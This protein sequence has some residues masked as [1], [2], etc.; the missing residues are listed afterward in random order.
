MSAR[1]FH[2]RYH[3][4]ALAGFMPLSLE[5]RGAYQTLL[6]MIYDRGGPVIDNDRLLAGYM[7]CSPRKWR[8]IRDA[9][10]EKG[11]IRVTED[12]HLTNDRAEKELENDAKTSRKLAES[13]SNGGRVRAERAKK[14]N[15]NREGGQASLE[16]PSSLTRSHIP[17]LEDKASSSVP[18][19]ARERGPDPDLAKVMEAGRFTSIPNDIAQ[20]R[21]WREA[22]AD[23]EGDIL[24]VV[25]RE[26]ESLIGRTGRGPFK[27]KVFD[28]AVRQKLADDAREAEANRRTV[29]NIR[30]LEQRQR[31]EDAREAEEA[32]RFQRRATA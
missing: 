19:P 4:D 17:E 13:G 7:Q 10:I 3:S 30:Q 28:N 22:G 16:R 14:A 9:L 12:G 1:P 8:V 27:L 21:A 23:L 31:E 32:A 25:R 18:R 5:E 15:E 11:K 2:K 24:P 26:T 29:D 20:L 6:D